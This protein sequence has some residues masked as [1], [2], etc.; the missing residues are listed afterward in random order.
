METQYLPPRVYVQ[1][2]ATKSLTALLSRRGEAN[3]RAIR[4]A[5]TIPAGEVEENETRRRTASR[6][7][8]GRKDREAHLSFC[9]SA[10]RHP[11]DRSTLS[12]RR[13][14]SPPLAELSRARTTWH[15][16]Y[17]R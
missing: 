3:A 5:R 2:R 12:V 4:G 10:V 6:L 9:T 11:G 16:T 14:R 1:R 13:R 8:E 15:R 7:L 17:L